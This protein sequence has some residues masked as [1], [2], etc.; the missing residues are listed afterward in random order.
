MMIIVRSGPEEAGRVGE[1]L[2]LSV[3]MIGLDELPTITFLDE[4]VRCL[5]PRAFSDATMQDYLQASADLI[6]INALSDSLDDHALNE[7]NLDP[8]LGATMIDLETLVELI[9]RCGMVAT[10]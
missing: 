9:L 8:V 4:G 3:A 5:L 10:F 2:R 6:G 7:K 1:A